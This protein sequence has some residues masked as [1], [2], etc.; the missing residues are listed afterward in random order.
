MSF[1]QDF[2]LL[3]RIGTVLVHA[4]WQG[5][6]LGALAALLLHGL[7]QRSPQVRYTWACAF[8]GLMVL[9]PILTWW[10]T[11]TPMAAG[12]LVLPTL[13]A[14]GLDGKPAFRGLSLSPSLLEGLAVLWC[15]GAGLML[16][17]ISGG[18]LLLE[19]V[20]VRRS[21]V[22]PE[23]WQLRVQALGAA[24]GLNRRVRLRL[25]SQAETPLVV[26]WLKP[27]ILL[28]SS[29]LLYLTPATLEAVLAHELAH[30]RRHDYFVN[31]LQSLV[32]ALLFFHPAAWW[33]SR[34]I[35]ELREHCC[36]DAAV[37]LTGHPELLAEGL[38]LLALLRRNPTPV[39]EPALGAAKGP[40]MFRIHRLLQPQAA[41]APSLSMLALALTGTL[42]LAQATPKEGAKPASPA[43]K[44]TKETPRAEKDTKASSKKGS[45]RS[46]AP[47]QV[48]PDG[49]ANM[50]FS[51]ITV[52]HQP[53]APSYPDAA[54][55]AKIQ[56]VVVVVLVIDENG[57]PT[58]VKAEQG[59]EELAP[60]AIAF[61]RGW[62]FEPAKLNG[63]PV[64]AR[65]KLTMPFKLR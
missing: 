62:R 59:P 21:T 9:A 5:A 52:K 10:F 48:G 25:S 16:L 49:V 13:L 46:V 56:G 45:A 29:A 35:R 12:E 37:A 26:G 64:K 14:E 36:D 51:K 23:D 42:V 55:E 2:P 8:L 31:L 58:E 32:E 65:F 57:I 40:L 38:S 17:R 20:Y 22:G 27:V 53:P 18:L 50:D 33:L 41:T 63:K 1:L 60:T 30:I 44:T 34:Q 39:P 4:L 61:A 7:R 24:M 3:L 47:T 11:P 15:V 54:K 28:P 6:V 19:Q 43:V